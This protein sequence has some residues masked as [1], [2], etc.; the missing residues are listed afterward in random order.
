MLR[1]FELHDRE[2]FE[3]FAY[4]LGPDDGSEYRQKLMADCDCFRDMQSLTST[5]SA[6]QIYDDGIDILIDLA[7]YTE[8][9]APEVFAL[10]P[11]PLQINYL[12][13]PGTLGA[14]YMDYII[15]DPVITPPHLAQ[16]ITEQ[17]LYLPDCYQINNNQQFLPQEIPTK[18]ALGLPE[19]GF[20]FC[21]F[22]KS[23][24]IEP[25]IFATWMRILKQVEN[26]VL[27]LLDSNPEVQ[28]N[29]ANAAQSLGVA[30]QRLIFAPRVPKPQHLTRHA[31]ADLFLDTH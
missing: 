18:S 30:S 17:C 24:K 14:D 16:F 27:W 23:E 5:Q 19:D 11:A 31:V 28:Q 4:S 8:Y 1:L 12:G 2:K 10:R 9:A 7:G 29:L 15:T 21:C 3:V 13:Y 26:S 6:Q 22:N 20:I 25:N